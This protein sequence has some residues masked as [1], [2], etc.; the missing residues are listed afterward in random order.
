MPSGV[1]STRWKKRLTKQRGSRAAALVVEEVSWVTDKLRNF[2]RW[3]TLHNSSDLWSLRRYSTQAKKEQNEKNSWRDKAEKRRCTCKIA[4]LPA[5]HKKY[6]ISC[7]RPRKKKGR[8]C[9]ERRTI[10]HPRKKSRHKQASV[11]SLHSERNHAE[12][13]SKQAN[14]HHR[15]PADIV[16]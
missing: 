4:I 6:F 7:L 5:T 8:R 15:F 12:S 9:S 14:E 10:H 2:G 1:L 16:G 3:L 11:S 13:H